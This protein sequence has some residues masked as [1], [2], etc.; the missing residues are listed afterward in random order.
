MTSNTFWARPTNMLQSQRMA[1]VHTQTH[2]HSAQLQR[3]RHPTAHDGTTFFPSSR[4][5]Y[6]CMSMTRVSARVLLCRG[7]T[8]CTSYV[9]VHSP[10]HAHTHTRTHEE[11][12]HRIGLHTTALS[13]IIEGRSAPLP[14]H[15]PE[16]RSADLKQTLARQRATQHG[17]ERL[18]RPSSS[19]H[20]LSLLPD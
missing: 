15:P 4:C 10:A 2:T 1:R 16:A 5:Q 8:S 18:S 20:S 12:W 6:A 17:T 9:Y 7:V 13:A 3:Q 19:L 14:P 11:A